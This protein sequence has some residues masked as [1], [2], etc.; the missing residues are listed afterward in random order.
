MYQVVSAVLADIADS[1]NVT[2]YGEALDTLRESNFDLVVL[3]LELP[4][5]WGLNLLP[6]LRAR[7]PSVPVLVFSV[8]ELVRARSQGV[9]LALVK[10][11]TSNDELLSA[12]ATLLEGGDLVDRTLPQAPAVH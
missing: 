11:R 8:H 3:D 12:I 2:S 4:D 10:S 9:S 7:M 1:V 5:G 6:D